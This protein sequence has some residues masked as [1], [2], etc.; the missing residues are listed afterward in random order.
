M[1]MDA[2][3]EI[4]AVVLSC[5]LARRQ[6]EPDDVAVEVVAEAEHPEAAYAS[7]QGRLV[8]GY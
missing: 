4:Q 7:G 2:Q 8:M 1:T 5:T 3:R 6:L